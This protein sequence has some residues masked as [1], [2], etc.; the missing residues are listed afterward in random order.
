MV[1]LAAGALGLAAGRPL[2]DAIVGVLADRGEVGP[3]FAPGASL[4][5]MAAALGMGVLIGQLAVAAAARRAGRIPPA[6]A[7]R[8]VA[9]EHPRPGFVR[10]LAGAAFLLGG[11]AMALVFSGFWAMVF[12]ILGGMVL[13]MGVGLL[14]RWLLGFPAALMG[15]PLRRLGAAGLLAG[16]GLA[17]NRWRT[18]SLATPIVLVTM[19][20]G[21]QGVVESSNQRHTEDVTRDRVHAS[22]IV[23]GSGGAPLPAASASEVAGLDGVTAVTAVA[24]TEVHPVDAALGDQSPWPAAALSGA[25]TGRTLDP[26][27]VRGS[28]DEVRGDAVA[29][30]RVFADAGDLRIGES[31]PVRMADTKPATLRVAAIYDRAAGLGDVLLDPAV[32]RRHAA[33]PADSALFVA[34]GTEAA[35]SLAGYAAAHPGVEALSRGEYLG[36]LHAANVDGSWGVWLVVG[37]AIVFAALALVNT[38]AMTTTERRDELATIRLLG[39]TTGH[40]VRMMALEMIPTVLVGLGAGAAIVAVAV[41]GVT[42][43]VTGFPLVVPLELVAGLAAGALVARPAR[44]RGHDAARPARLPGGGDARQG[45]RP[46]GSSRLHPRIVRRVGVHRRASALAGFGAQLVVPGLVAVDLAQPVA[47]AV[48]GQP[49]GTGGPDV[50]RVPLHVLGRLGG[51]HPSGGRLLR[52]VLRDRL[53]EESLLVRRG[54]PAAVDGEANSAGRGVG[55]GPAQGTEEI[56]VELGDARDLV[57][58]DRRAFGDGAAGLADAER[59]ALATERRRWAMPTVEDEDAGHCWLSAATA[60]IT[61]NRPAMR[62]RGWSAVGHAAIEGSAVL[63]ARMRF[64][65][66]RRYA[67]ARSIRACVS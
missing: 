53:A 9:I 8:E 12:A 51:G 67:P 42:E 59:R 3:A 46:V 65:I 6:D 22:R 13:A 7:L 40:A 16:T 23:V 47:G 14:G 45:M 60:A 61:S 21:I 57:V 34:G 5:P 20:V 30:S 19:L 26:D 28:L 29:V 24:S 56:G 55:R 10:T 27:V 63:P 33:D 1:S 43:G 2:A 11:V 31:F 44:R 52:A 62:I 39:G 50:D 18:A 15:V 36:S 48:R 32:A 66:C 54:T 38:A 64:S 37:L 35:R 58:E 41:S 49:R 17:A 4:I 25:R